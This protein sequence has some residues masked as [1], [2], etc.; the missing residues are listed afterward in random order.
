MTEVSDP[1]AE[2][3]YLRDVQYRTDGNLAARQS[4]YAY[5]HPRI[6]LAARVLDRALSGLAASDSAVSD[7]ATVADVGCGNGMYLAELARRRFSGRVVG[8][9]LSIGMLAAARQ[10]VERPLS[11][12]LAG[13]DAT[14]LPLRDAAADLALAMHMLYHVPDPLAA[15]SELRRITKPGGRVVIGLN[16]RDHLRELRDVIAAARGA[17]RVSVHERVS[18]DAGERLAKTFFA[19]VTRHDFAAELRV[20]AVEPLAGYVRSMSGTGHGADP[21][22]LVAAVLSALPR[23][24]DGSFTITTHAGCLICEV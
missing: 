24:A 4:I 11:L 10:R 16:G 8:A 20:P 12:A 18:L 14:A 19:K 13:A 5:Q 23:A 1:W 9:D 6:D 2:R 21:D 3:G 22:R 7:S 17:D 15:V